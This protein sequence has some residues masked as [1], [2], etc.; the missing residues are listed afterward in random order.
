M[1]EPDH[2]L[3]SRVSAFYHKDNTRHHKPDPRVF[4]EVLK[5]HN[6]AP[7][8]C[9]Y[10]G[11]SPSDAVAAKGAGLYFIASLESGLRRKQDFDPALVDSY[12]TRFPDV[13]DA[14]IELDTVAKK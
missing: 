7:Q 12:V 8:N 14:V 6:F 11:D 5:A 2:L 1:L 3:A 13:V 4:D 9:A 10:I